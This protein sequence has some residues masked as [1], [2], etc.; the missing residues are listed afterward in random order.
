MMEARRSEARWLLDRAPFEPE[1]A[2]RL[3][4]I[5]ADYLECG[6][7]M[8]IGLRAWLAEGL[9]AGAAAQGSASGLPVEHARAASMATALGVVRKAGAP[10]KF[11][12][13]RDVRRTVWQYGDR[14][15]ETT[16]AKALS[17]AY[18]VGLT[19]AR[20]RIKEAIARRP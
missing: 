20:K 8:P 18:G 11:I 4:A 6:E 16:L 3:L 5:A 2:A 14:V 10:T 13:W 1:A 9:R 12:S 7:R 17:E 15:S 19:T